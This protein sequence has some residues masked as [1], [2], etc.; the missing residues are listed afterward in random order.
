MVAASGPLNVRGTVIGLL[1]SPDRE[2]AT[3]MTLLTLV[4]DCPL[5]SVA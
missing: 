2:T 4:R 3:R 1:V 5:Q